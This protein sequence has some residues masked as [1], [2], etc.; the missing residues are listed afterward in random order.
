[1]TAIANAVRERAIACVLVLAAVLAALGISMLA[2][3]LWSG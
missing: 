3:G 1:V 2:R